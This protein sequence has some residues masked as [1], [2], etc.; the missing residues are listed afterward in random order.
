MKKLK[1]QPVLPRFLSNISPNF[2]LNFPPKI[3]PFF[4]SIFV[5]TLPLFVSG[6]SE[7]IANL[8]NSVL[9]G[10]FSF[11]DLASVSYGFLIV[12]SIVSISQGAISALMPSMQQ[13]I[14]TLDKNL[15]MITMMT[16]FSYLVFSV[17]IFFIVYQS[18]YYLDVSELYKQTIHL[19]LLPM[20]VFLLAGQVLS[21]CVNILIIIEKIKVIAVFG[22]CA[23]SIDVITSSMLVHGLFGLPRLGAQGAALGSMMGSLTVLFLLLSTL[24][25]I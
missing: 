9:T 21:Y 10:N 4:I 25:N 18:V 14:K 19:Y 17:V 12:I 6:F 22:L 11:I 3:L 2:L 23:T 24:K 1:K 13:A 8:I 15:L 20:F 5:L 7:Q 16:L